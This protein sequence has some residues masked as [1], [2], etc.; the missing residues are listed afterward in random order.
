[1]N[2]KF[3]Y[4][5]DFENSKKNLYKKWMNVLVNERMNECTQTGRQTER[6]RER[7]RETNIPSDAFGEVIVT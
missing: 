7:D 2:N 6:E 3:L 1:L 4:L 5:A